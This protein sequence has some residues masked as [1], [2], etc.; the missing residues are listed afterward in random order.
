METKMSEQERLA[1]FDAAKHREFDSFAAEAN[2]SDKFLLIEGGNYPPCC[3]PVYR[4]VETFLMTMQQ[5]EEP[6]DAEE[7]EIATSKA[8]VEEI[9]RCKKLVYESAQ[10]IVEAYE[11]GN[12]KHL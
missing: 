10:D 2:K 4:D 11:H 12:Q 3:I 1:C 7:L 6:T 9:E 5:I 8:S